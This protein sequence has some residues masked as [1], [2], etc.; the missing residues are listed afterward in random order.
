M[1][2]CE[3][4]VNTDRDTCCDRCAKCDTLS[5][6]AHYVHKANKALLECVACTVALFARAAAVVAPH[7]A[8]LTN[9]LFAPPGAAVLEIM[10]RRSLVTL[11]YPDLSNSL[12]H[13]HMVFFR[14]AGGAP[15]VGN[16]V[17]VL[18]AMLAQQHGR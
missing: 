4:P 16:V 8:G 17:T 14:P 10:S 15:D 1:R 5:C 13:R 18:R 12:G 11:C 9:A 6:P 2:L 3:M 7:G